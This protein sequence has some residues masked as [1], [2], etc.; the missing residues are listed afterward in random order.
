MSG[1]PQAP[2]P[3]LSRNGGV[4]CP[5]DGEWFQSTVEYHEH[6]QTSHGGPL[7]RRANNDKK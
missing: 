1:E 5:I 4:E 7:V 2:D 3:K 6:W